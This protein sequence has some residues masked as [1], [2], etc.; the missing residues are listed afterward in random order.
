VVD[1]GSKAVWAP[2]SNPDLG[3][4]GFRVTDPQGR[5]QYVYLNPSDTSANAEDEPMVPNVF[6][7]VGAAGNPSADGAV[8]SVDV[9][10]YIESGES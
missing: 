5:Q 3:V 10:Q 6:I 7:Y 9:L 4:V 1:T 2:W 8:T